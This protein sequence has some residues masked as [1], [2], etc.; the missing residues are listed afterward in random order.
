MPTA[1]PKTMNRA[2]LPAG[3]NSAAVT[4]TIQMT[5]PIRIVFLAPCRWASR[6]KSSAPKNATNCT[7]RMVPM[8][9]DCPWPSCSE[10]YV[11]ELAMTVWMPSLK[12][13]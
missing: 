9:T 2:T 8:S 6:P 10:P 4:I 13:R 3:R 5:S 7:S 1:T 11:E 12:N